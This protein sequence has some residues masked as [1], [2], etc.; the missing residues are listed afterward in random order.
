[1]KKRCDACEGSGKLG[2]QRETCW[3]CGGRG[4]LDKHPKEGDANDSTE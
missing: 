3:F 1:M 4:S 2:L